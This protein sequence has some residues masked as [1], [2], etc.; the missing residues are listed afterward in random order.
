MSS[1]VSENASSPL[2]R[3][4]SVAGAIGRRRAWYLAIVIALGLYAGLPWLAPVFMKLGW[5]SPARILYLAYSTQCHQLANRSYFLFGPEWMVSPDGLEA[6]G[7]E[8]S[9]TGLRAFLGSPE[10]GWKVAWSDR[11]VSMYTSAF[12]FLLIAPLSTRLRRPLPLGVFLLMILPL[13]IDGTT[14]FLSDLEGFGRGFRDSNAWLS[15]LTNGRLP[16]EFY[17]GDA[18]GSFNATARLVTG[19]LF[20]VG[21]AWALVPRILPDLEEIVGSSGRLRP[22]P[23]APERGPTPSARFQPTIGEAGLPARTAASD[24]PTYGGTHGD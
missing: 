22:G 23:L 17:A 9:M 6:A 4:P 2:V 3:T 14:H 5:E 13:A 21:A 11:M 12:L 24:H 8:P 20:G 18:W 19:I 16:V 1:S 15:T 7:A 10:I